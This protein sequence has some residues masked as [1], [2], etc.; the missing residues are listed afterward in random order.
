M[1]KKFLICFTITASSVILFSGCADHKSQ[2]SDTA[3]SEQSIH[4]T[5][6]T[7]SDHG[8]GEQIPDGQNSDKQ[9]PNTQ[10][11]AEQDSQNSSVQTGSA[12]S[13]ALTSP[14]LPPEHLA[15]YT[16][17][18]SALQKLD[19][20]SLLPD[21]KSV[22]EKPG[23]YII[24]DVD[25]DGVEDLVL[26]W[27]TSSSFG[28]QFYIYG[29]DRA[30][31]SFHVKWNQSVSVKL[32]DLGTILKPVPVNYGLS[33]T[34]TFYPYGF[35][36]FHSEKKTYIFQGYVDAWQKSYLQVDYAGNSYPSK[37]DTEN[38]GMVYCI[39]YCSEGTDYVND[40]SYSQSQYDTFC[41][42]TFGTQITPDNMIAFTPENIEK[43]L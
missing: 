18:Q 6:A 9:D 12:D 8:S 4:A 31:D 3:G 23:Y 35:Y 19:Q 2:Q 34:D 36:Q 40:Y 11:P 27:E 29:Y 33:S 26:S 38:T 37:I 43:I 7:A 16:A 13:S 1:L 10:N 21:D 24:Q 41:Q 5:A 28:D 14:T 17:C 15:V 22:K 30:S 39:T 20:Q 32:Y 25:A 42:E